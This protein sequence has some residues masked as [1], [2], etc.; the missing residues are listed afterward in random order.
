MD[1][2]IVISRKKY[3]C[4]HRAAIIMP[5]VAVL[6]VIV[7]WWLLYG[8]SMI[9]GY[10]LAPTEGVWYCEEL[11]A[12]VDFGN[13]PKNIMTDANGIQYLFSSHSKSHTVAVYTI[14]EI[15]PIEENGE[16][17]YWYN[18]GDLVYEFTYVSLKSN[19][20][21]IQDNDGNRYIFVRK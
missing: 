6:L 2:L 19:R 3:A 14:A 8:V 11:G 16:I 5:I 4:L 10:K 17:R 21:T 20:Y 1:N 12:E 7:L 13:Q 18:Y 9:F 15:V